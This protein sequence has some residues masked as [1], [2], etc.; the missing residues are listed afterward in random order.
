[1]A[2][3]YWK[4]HN[5]FT[6]KSADFL[7]DSIGRKIIKVHY[8]LLP[9]GKKWY[10]GDS[11]KPWNEA[12]IGLWLLLKNIRK[13]GRLG[14]LHNRRT[15]FTSRW[16]TLPQSRSELCTTTMQGIRLVM[17][18]TMQSERKSVAGEWNSFFVS[19]KKLKLPRFN[20]RQT[21]ELSL[22]RY[23]IM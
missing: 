9:I 2:H 19:S 22:L 23:D 8:E 11:L 21:C 12:V 14:K 18:V 6:W 10:W 4:I 15:N 1:M 13:T 17:F 16:S 20:L 7:E 5:K 3:V